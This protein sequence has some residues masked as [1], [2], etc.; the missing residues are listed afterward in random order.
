M[1]YYLDIKNKSLVRDENIYSQG[2]SSSK[3]L[4]S[5]KDI[6]FTY[7]HFDPQ[8]REC[9]WGDSANGTPLAVKIKVI[10]RG[11]NKKD[12]EITRTALIPAQR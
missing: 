6:V 5:I 1:S 10:F 11:E 4:A 2:S 7:Y 3:A 12:V 9:V 8:T